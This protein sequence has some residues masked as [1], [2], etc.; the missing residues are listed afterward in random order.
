M[1]REASVVVGDGHIL[2]IRDD[3]WPACEHDEPVDAT[4]AVVLPGFTNAHY[5]S[6]DN[7]FRGLLDGLP[8]EGWV[9]RWAALAENATAQEYGLAALGGALELVRS[10]VTSVID[11]IGPLDARLR[12]IT[13]AY[14]Q[15]GLRATVAP[16]LGDTDYQGRRVG[17]GA[18]AQLL[19]SF[20][21]LARAE[22]DPEAGVI[23]A[24][25]P[26]ATQR[27]SPEL[28]LG[29]VEIC[30]R[31]NLPVHL[32]LDE[33][34]LQARRFREA[35]GVSSTCW[36]HANGMLD[37]RVG[38]A[39]GVWLQSE[40]IALLATTGASLVHNPLSN[41]RLGSG[42]A[43]VADLLAAGV[44]VALGTDGV[45]S[46]GALDLFAAMRA[47]LWTSRLR[48]SDPGRWVRPADVLTMAW[49]GDQAATGATARPRSLAPGE[50]GDVVVV[51]WDA[52]ALGPFRGE[53]APLVSFGRPDHVRSVM[54]GG[55]TVL[56]D[57]G[58][59]SV[60]EQSVHAQLQAVREAV[61]RRGQP[62]SGSPTAIVTDN[63]PPDGAVHRPRPMR[64]GQT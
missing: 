57:G 31:L 48:E 20:E 2:E 19:A 33:T 60:D 5:H 53:M 56:A 29:L 36:L 43:P 34:E 10:G 12:A 18:T 47:A 32:H 1:L 50:G 52:R 8:M 40:D 26:A 21:S 3:P 16:L 54:S 7:A 44:T 14:R 59:T 11:H 25:G 63:P 39:H 9:A 41:M 62:T 64:K 42:L 51:D 23:V 6:L 35:H 22:H 38:L 55:T 46:C 37:A 58:F 17:S 4:G 13:D 30:A 61:D 24:A 45:E 15:V 27:C 49:S 28:L